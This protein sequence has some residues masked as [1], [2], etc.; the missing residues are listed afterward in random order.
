M[1]FPAQES[2][3]AESSCHQVISS[4]SPGRMEVRRHRLYAWKR[5]AKQDIYQRN[6]RPFRRIGQWLRGTRD[7]PVVARFCAFFIQL[8][9]DVGV[10][11]AVPMIVLFGVFLRTGENTVMPFVRPG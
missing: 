5:P 4:H 3:F 6:T 1:S 2:E 10:Y 11:G 7:Y 8:V 9:F